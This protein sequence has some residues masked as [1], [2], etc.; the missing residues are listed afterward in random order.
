MGLP[1]ILEF[2]GGLNISFRAN[3]F[4]KPFKKLIF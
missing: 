3:P 2:W 1:E 4:N